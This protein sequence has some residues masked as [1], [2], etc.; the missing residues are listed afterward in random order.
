MKVIRIRVKTLDQFLISKGC[1][2]SDPKFLPVVPYILVKPIN[3]AR[4]GLG[5][6]RFVVAFW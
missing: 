1:F 2:Y 3:G 5:R 4:P 6:C